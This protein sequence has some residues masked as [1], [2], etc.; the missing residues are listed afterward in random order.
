M[1]GIVG[2]LGV[3]TLARRFS[4]QRPAAVI[5]SLVAMVGF[6]GLFLA[7]PQTAIL[8]AILFGIGNGGALSLALLLIVL[9]SA[10][11]HVAAQL[12]SMAQSAGY[13]IAAT[14]PLVTGLLHT[15]LGGWSASIWFLALASLACLLTG[16]LAGYDR[17]VGSRGV[18]RPL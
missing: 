12:S 5:V 15:L 2:S 6:L 7:P 11:E 18:V 1:L 3:P 9:R 8:W 10:D 17:V 4:D 14:G 16:F 13:L